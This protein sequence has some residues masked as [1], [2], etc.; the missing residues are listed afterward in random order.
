MLRGL[1]G[2]ILR[3]HFDN[4]YA[5]RERPLEVSGLA[6]DM[7]SSKALLLGVVLYCLNRCEDSCKLR[8]CKKTSFS[9]ILQ[10]SAPLA[11]HLSFYNR[12]TV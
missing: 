7:R 10:T 9:R 5:L 1:W 2:F 11:L 4:F 12:L 3:F 6:P 8:V